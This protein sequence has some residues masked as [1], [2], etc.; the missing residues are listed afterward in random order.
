MASSLLVTVSSMLPRVVVF[1]FFF[2]DVQLI[3]HNP[4]V[5]IITNGK[6]LSR[7]MLVVFDLKLRFFNVSQ[8]TSNTKGDS[9][10]KEKES[11]FLRPDINFPIGE[12]GEMIM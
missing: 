9:F 7:F 5:R 3:V 4:I 2:S 11:P 12:T 1:A 10:R 8:I 6:K